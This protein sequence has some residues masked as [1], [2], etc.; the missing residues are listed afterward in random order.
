MQDAIT[1]SR[2]NV[3]ETVGLTE[4]HNHVR[5]ERSST[6]SLVNVCGFGTAQ[7]AIQVNTAKQ[8]AWRGAA[9]CVVHTEGGRN[10]AV[11]FEDGDGVTWVMVTTFLTI[12]GGVCLQTRVLVTTKKVHRNSA[13]GVGKRVMVVGD[14]SANLGRDIGWDGH[15]HVQRLETFTTLKGRRVLDVVESRGLRLEDSFDHVGGTWLAFQQRQ[16]I[17]AVQATGHLRSHGLHDD[18]RD[19][20]S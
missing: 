13:T 19:G 14:H 10:L 3:F 4:L 8:L 1:F 11:R 2:G 16:L 17:F 6:S 12:L 7:V 5:S 15:V 20:R 9:G 18:G